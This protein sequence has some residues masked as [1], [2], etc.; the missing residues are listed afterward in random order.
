M[1][2]LVARRAQVAAELADTLRSLGDTRAARRRDWGVAFDHAR[3]TGENITTVRATADRAV[4]HLDEEVDR[5]TGEAEAL[6]V[7]LGQIDFEAAH[8]AG[9]E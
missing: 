3:M 7:E 1:S 2:T 4:N 5:L 9:D 6:R 8:G